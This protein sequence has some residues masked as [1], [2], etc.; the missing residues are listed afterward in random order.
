MG[1]QLAYRGLVQI[2]PAKPCDR[3]HHHGEDDSK[4]W[5]IAL[6]IHHRESI[7]PTAVKHTKHNAIGNALREWGLL[8]G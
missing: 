1:S 3:I 7:P 4:T 5:G 2:S 6:E 8:Y